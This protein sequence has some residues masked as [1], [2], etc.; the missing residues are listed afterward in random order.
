MQAGQVDI[1]RNVR[2]SVRSHFFY[3]VY[4]CDNLFLRDKVFSV[5][6][7]HDVAFFVSQFFSRNDFDI[8]FHARLADDLGYGQIQRFI[9]RDLRYFSV[10]SL[11]F[12][13]AEKVIDLHDIDRCV[14]I[15]VQVR[16]HRFLRIHDKVDVKVIPEKRT[17]QFA[18]VDGCVLARRVRR[19][20]RSFHFAVF[21]QRSRI[22]RRQIEFALDRQFQRRIPFL[23]DFRIM[24]FKRDR[25]ARF[26]RVVFFDGKT[27]IPSCDIDG[28][29]F[30]RHAQV[31]EVLQDQFDTEQV[32]RLAFFVISEQFRLHFGRIRR[33]VSEFF[34]G[35]AFGRFPKVRS[36]ISDTQSDEYRIQRRARNIRHQHFFLFRVHGDEQFTRKFG[37]FRA[38]RVRRRV[39]RS[40]F[41]R[42]FLAR[43]EQPAEISF[44]VEIETFFNGFQ[45]RR[46]VRKNDRFD[47]ENGKVQIDI[48]VNRALS[49]AFVPFFQGDIQAQH[50]AHIVVA[51]S[52]VQFVPMFLVQFFVC[53]RSVFARHKF[54]F[55]HYVSEE[56]FVVFILQSRRFVQIRLRHAARIAA[57]FVFQRSPRRFVV[58][59]SVFESYA[60]PFEHGVHNVAPMLHSDVFVVV[61]ARR[62]RNIQF[63]I[64][65]IGERE[66]VHVRPDLKIVRLVEHVAGVNARS[67][68]NAYAHTDSGI[69]AVEQRAVKKLEQVV[70]VERFVL[71]VTD[72]NASIAADRDA[73]VRKLFNGNELGIVHRRDPVGQTCVDFAQA[74]NDFRL[75]FFVVFKIN[76]RLQSEVLVKFHHQIHAEIDLAHF[77]G[78]VY[79]HEEVQNVQY[80]RFLHADTE[81]ALSEQEVEIRLHRRIEYRTCV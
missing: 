49:L 33:I 61:R 30:N 24:V 26:D 72:H 39:R 79:A 29:R 68:H 41:F 54:H 45:E 69:S 58:D 50:V 9:R 28:G 13:T 12:D 56:V 22:V 8:R 48:S 40:L 51:A 31:E 6:S 38:A 75:F 43:V 36:D 66:Q 5:V 81:F 34:F 67:V 76:R 19:T 77:F 1:Q 64:G 73:H 20:E 60:F 74:D 59:R 63:D 42:V 57:H 10:F 18:H 46:Y 70:E 80:R 44:V 65:Q 7:F 3:K 25:V 35:R 55:L 16:S 17:E 71:F 53:K 32:V 15:E 4:T 23:G 52:A 2:L 14:N 27:F 11:H 78:K 37:E 21:F 62:E 47:A